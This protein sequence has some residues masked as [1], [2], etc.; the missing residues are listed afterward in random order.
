MIVFPAIDL[1]AGRCVRLRQGDP[2]QQQVF[3]EDPVE[4]ARK[5]E[6]AGARALHVVDLDGAFE[7]RPANLHM[8]ARIARAVSVPIQLGGGLRSIDSIARALVAGADRV[9]LGTA[10]I[11][12]GLLAYAVHRWGARVLV[13]IDARS[14]MVAVRGWREVTAVRAADLALAVQKAGVSEIIYTDISRDGMLEGPNF[15]SIAEMAKMGARI[16]ASGGVSR[17]EDVRRLAELEP[18]GI[19]GVIIGKAL[20]T[21]AIS[22]PEAIGVASERPGARVELGA[23][24]ADDAEVSAEEAITGE[25]AS[26]EIGKTGG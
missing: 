3:S 10:A 25:P 24:E 15:E 26:G 12:P 8:V 22:L 9:I 2:S 4:V 21:G 6:A 1:R 19:T 16:I 20:Y 17:L 11:G 23:L 18:E 7:G 14:G 5:W 13:G